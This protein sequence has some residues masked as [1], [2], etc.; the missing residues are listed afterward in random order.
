MS[1]TP[2]RFTGADLTVLDGQTVLS[3]VPVSS[4]GAASFATTTVPAGYHSMTASWAGNGDVLA[5]VSAVLKEQIQASTATTVAATGPVTY[6]QSV[7]VTAT[8]TPAGVTGSVMFNDGGTN[9]GD[10]SR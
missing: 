6:L 9:L 4:S 5:G 7:S 10:G 1:M 3:V 2:C 8:V